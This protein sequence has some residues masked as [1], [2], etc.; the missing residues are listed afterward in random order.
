MK[1]HCISVK[2]ASGDDDT[3]VKRTNRLAIRP[4]NVGS[5]FE[6]EP[7]WVII[8]PNAIYYLKSS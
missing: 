7:L 4:F 1:Q 6:I 3:N 8:R 2:K 5:G